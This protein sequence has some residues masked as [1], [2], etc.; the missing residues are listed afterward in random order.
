[1][2]IRLNLKIF[3]FIIIFIFTRQIEVYGII[4]FFSI[5]HE[6]GH[7]IACIFLGFKPKMIEIMPFGLSIGFESKCDNYNLKIKKATLLTLKKIII[8]IS[9]PIT[10]IICIIICIFLNNYFLWLNIDLI[11][12]ANII[13]GV[14]NLIPIYPLDGGRIIKYIINIYCGRKKS[15]EYINIISNIVISIL[16]AVCSIVILCFKNNVEKVKIL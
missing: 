11:I 1:M 14:F 7:M 3:I 10:N 8:S 2:K 9:G 16:T 4:M 13:I 12:Y 6:L 5:L 15:Y